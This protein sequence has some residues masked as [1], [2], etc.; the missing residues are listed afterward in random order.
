MTSV[1]APRSRSTALILTAVLTASGIVHAVKPQV[2]DPVV[3]RSL[4][5]SA[6][7]WTRASGYAEWGIAAL[8]ASRRTQSIGGVVAAA[9]FVAVFPANVRT[10]RVVR[11]RG[12]L[13]V[14]IAVL[15]LPLQIP[16]VLMSVSAAQA[17]GRR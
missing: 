5:G 10:V 17:N 16:L 1:T 7:L 3:P 15:R 13:A 9:F 4:P 6:R 14:V 11:K 12:A 2:F 8:L